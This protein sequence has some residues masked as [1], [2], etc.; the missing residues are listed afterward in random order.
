MAQKVQRQGAK[1]ERQSVKAMKG[2][3]VMCKGWAGRAV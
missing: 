1:S 2:V 3:K